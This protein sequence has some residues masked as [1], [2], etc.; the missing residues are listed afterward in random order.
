MGMKSKIVLTNANG[1]GNFKINAIKNDGTTKVITMVKDTDY[2]S[3]GSLISL[4]TSNDFST[5]S[6]TS[7]V[8]QDST[9]ALVLDPGTREKWAT[10]ALNVATGAAGTTSGTKITGPASDATSGLTDTTARINKN[11]Y[12]EYNPNSGMVSLK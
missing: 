6:I 3:S 11:K 9:L 5:A 2:T 1:N 10:A 8:G 12:W 7:S 4:S